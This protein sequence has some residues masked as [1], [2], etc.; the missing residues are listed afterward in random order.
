MFPGSK[1]QEKAKQNWLGKVRWS[2]C[3]GWF[4]GNNSQLGMEQHRF[5]LDLE[6][7]ASKASHSERGLVRPWSSFPTPLSTKGSQTRKCLG[8]LS[9]GPMLPINTISAFPSVL[10]AEIKRGKC[11]YCTHKPKRLIFFQAKVRASS[12]WV[13][14]GEGGMI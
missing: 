6:Q 12:C 3:G 5:P 4:R 2:L 1:W 8:N 7:A 10:R 11:T 14:T 9:S 13:G